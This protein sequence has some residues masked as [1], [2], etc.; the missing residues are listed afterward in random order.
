MTNFDKYVAEAT[1]ANIS[2]ADVYQSQNILES[3]GSLEYSLDSNMKSGM[4]EDDMLQELKDIKALLKTDIL[5][6]L[7][8]ASDYAPTVSVLTAGTAGTAQFP[9]IS[10]SDLNWLTEKKIT[11]FETLGY[12]LSIMRRLWDKSVSEGL[13]YGSEKSL[14]SASGFKGQS[15]NSSSTSDYPKDFPVWLKDLYSDKS[16]ASKDKKAS[17][18]D[19]AKTLLSQFKWMAAPA[20][21]YLEIIKNM[22]DFAKPLRDTAASELTK[23]KKAGEH[24]ARGSVDVIDTAWKDAQAARQRNRNIGVSDVGSQPDL[25][26]PTPVVA[27]AS[28]LQPASIDFPTSVS[29]DN[30]GDFELWLETWLKPMLEEGLL[31]DVSISQSLASLVEKSEAHLALLL[32]ISEVLD[33]AVL[34][35]IVY[36]AG[37]DRV[38]GV[39]GIALPEAEQVE[40]LSLPIST[41]A[42]RSQDHSLSEG[43]LVTP[44][45]NPEVVSPVTN[46]ETTD[47]VATPVTNPETADLVATPVTNPEVTTPSWGSG[48]LHSLG[49]T[50]EDYKKLQEEKD[51]TPLWTSVSSKFEGRTVEDVEFEDLTDK[52][53]KAEVEKDEKQSVVDST[54]SMFDGLRKAVV[55][56]KEES[57]EES[58]QTQGLLKDMTGENKESPFM[59]FLTS[60][61][62]GFT[63][64]FSGLSGFFSPAMIF[65]L[66]AL[67]TYFSSEGFRSFVNGIAKFAWDKT[68]DFLDPKKRDDVTSEVGGAFA[69]TAAGAVATSKG[70][71]AAS[72][73][74]G[75]TSQVA[76]RAA[77][78]ATIGGRGSTALR[79][80]SGA[81][82]IASGVSK[83]ASSGAMKVAGKAGALGFGIEALNTGLGFIGLDAEADEINS[84][85][86]G[87]H[88]GVFKG[89]DTSGLIIDDA[90]A[91]KAGLDNLTWKDYAS[92]AFNGAS[93]GAV[94][95]GIGGPWVSAIA[96]AIGAG[97]S[98]YGLSEEAKNDYRAFAKENPQA[99][100]QMVAAKKAGLSMDRFSFKD[101]TG[102]GTEGFVKW[103]QDN[104]SEISS[105]M[106]YSDSSKEGL[107]NS[108]MATWYL[109]KSRPKTAIK[110]LPFSEVAKS[111]MPS[112]S[113]TPIMKNGKVSDVAVA[114]LPLN[115]PGRDSFIENVE[116]ALHGDIFRSDASE[117][118]KIVRNLSEAG[119]AMY[120]EDEGV[121]PTTSSSRISLRNGLTKK[122]GVNIK[123]VTDSGIVNFVNGLPVNAN[124]S[125]GL[126]TKAE[127]DYLRKRDG[128]PPGG[129]S[130]HLTGAAVDLSLSKPLADFFASK[131]GYSYLL[132]NNIDAH[133]LWSEVDKGKK[134]HFHVQPR[135]LSRWNNL[136]YSGDG[137]DSYKEY[138]SMRK[139]VLHGSGLRYLADS[140]KMLDITGV[141]LDDYKTSKSYASKKATPQSVVA[142]APQSV[143]ASA[144]QG[145]TA[146]TVSSDEAPVEAD[147][148]QWYSGITDFIDSV[149]SLFKAQPAETAQTSTK[150]VTTGSVSVQAAPA[151]DSGDPSFM[152]EVISN[153]KDVNVQKSKP[154]PL[155]THALN[156]DL[157]AS[158]DPQAV[159]KSSGSGGFINSPSTSNT[160]NN[161]NMI[162]VKSNLYTKQS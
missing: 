137:W 129:K 75:R 82:K 33:L 118:A 29:I 74:L 14:V 50:E 151:Q 12:N 38:M 127:Q 80:I 102:K 155:R 47:L 24:L 132:N 6:A 141:N 72:N 120:V 160:V 41:E 60:L 4:F 57:K 149:G 32:Y 110:D 104:K 131:A 45:T 13:G 25:S 117:R 142:S 116:D 152:G 91:A 139:K 114:V 96:A 18:K 119:D 124:I 39:P 9:D 161:N 138:A 58:D 143:V 128:L 123:D 43:L 15:L 79:S 68:K 111:V 31:T 66:G 30:F 150:A 106:S 1:P 130:H 67:I 42:E 136:F 7:T 133:L 37:V 147:S 56:L 126:R 28:E 101:A 113:S 154:L 10:K 51:D 135:S 64:L 21:P 156:T 94:T 87:K 105:A 95:G 157:L 109:A 69:S 90:F 11:N 99:F 63:S 77:N 93:L 70:L 88:K 73:A 52:T 22:W 62:S 121:L 85:W 103:V 83:L 158:K 23:L 153:F 92:S 49:Y 36:N 17:Y 27:E 8:R 125:S 97:V 84:A 16:S 44:V 46:P 146:N 89:L 140:Q 5:Q 78:I 134:S 34:N 55:E 122:P 20:S 145:V 148:T 71:G 86:S 100:L 144:S 2:K 112:I 81:S 61:L 65:G 162:N 76:S 107:Y 19:S 3:L 59:V 26:V 108:L 115:V 53:F 98:I 159:S 48:L 40:D 35:K 54:K